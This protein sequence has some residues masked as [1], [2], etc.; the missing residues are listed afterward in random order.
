MKGEKKFGD[1]SETQKAAFHNMDNINLFIL[2]DALKMIVKKGLCKP[3]LEICKGCPIK[4]MTVN[5]V[6]YGGPMACSLI[7]LEA[8]SR[9]RYVVLTTM[10]GVECDQCG[11]GIPPGGNY[12]QVPQFGYRPLNF[13]VHC[14]EMSQE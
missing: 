10:D 8:A 5:R 12:V 1:L 3:R 14:V 13:C 11:A 4:K 6:G 9:G 2:H 7:M